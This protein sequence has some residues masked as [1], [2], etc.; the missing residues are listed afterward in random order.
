MYYH[1]DEFKTLDNLNSWLEERW[2]EIGVHDQEAKLDE[3]YSD[4]MSVWRDL[5]E[6]HYLQPVCSAMFKLIEIL[7]DI[8]ERERPCGALGYF[9]DEENETFDDETSERVYEE[10]SNANND[11]ARQAI[12]DVKK[13]LWEVWDEDEAIAR[14]EDEDDEEESVN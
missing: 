9:T 14:A 1:T 13:L 10:R 4:V 8:N 2:N 6:D 11:R 5:D 3:A 7:Q 12:D